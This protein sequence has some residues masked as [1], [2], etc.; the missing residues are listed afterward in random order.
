MWMARAGVGVVR[1]DLLYADAELDVG[2]LAVPLFHTPIRMEIRYR[3]CRRVPHVT[4]PTPQ[5]PGRDASAVAVP[6]AFW[7]RLGQCIQTFRVPRLVND[8]RRSARTF[9]GVA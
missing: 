7:C 3:A 2:K 9:D 6:V 4:A 1:P 5:H 8:G